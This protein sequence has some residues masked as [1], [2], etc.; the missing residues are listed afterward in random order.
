MNIMFNVNYIQK[1]KTISYTH[2]YSTVNLA[3]T[4]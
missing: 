3:Y 4:S 1:Q 2:Y